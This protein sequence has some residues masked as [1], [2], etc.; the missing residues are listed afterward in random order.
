[1]NPVRKMRQQAAVAFLLC[2]LGVSAAAPSAASQN[3]A[4][5]SA[6]S[7]STASSAVSSAT[8]VPPQIAALIAQIDAL[9][10]DAASADADYVQKLMDAYDALS[11][12]ERL[13]V[14]NSDRLSEIYDQLAQSGAVSR[15]AS[16]TPTPDTGAADG[17]KVIQTT[18]YRFSVGEK[19]SLSI[20]VRFVTDLDGDGKGDIPDR[21]V[22]T[23]PY[24]NTTPITRT[25]SSLHD[26]TMDI[27]LIWEANF[28]QRDIRSAETGTWSL[29]TSA[30][31]TVSRMA[32]A[33]ARKKIIP[34]S[35]SIKP[36]A[37]GTVSSLTPVPEESE[38][39][40][41][42]T[43]ETGSSANGGLVR[44]AAIAVIGIALMVFLFRFS[45]KSGKKTETKTDGYTAE[46]PDD[47]KKFA[48]AE[49][50]V[51]SMKAAMEQSELAE[52]EESGKVG[53]DPDQAD[54]GQEAADDGNLSE[55]QEADDGLTSYTE[56]DT[57][58][59]T[60]EDRPGQEPPQQPEGP[61]E[62]TADDAEADSDDA[63][64]GDLS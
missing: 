53:A 56:G 35:T 4:S 64:F 42:G 61:L 33:G 24:G 30:A 62:E 52:I 17:D 51:E 11:L 2:A 22:L 10:D 46:E 50:D 1:M 47:L 16:G 39:P 7:G 20:V 29:E 60:K 6:L 27:D 18:R 8:S 3:T 55:E 43:E 21:M 15:A 48:D 41:V 45:K 26:N 25:A 9:P 34:E 31:V 38:A 40:A 54:T 12:S 59:L 32:Y 44:T 36:A 63:D 5:S 13:Q 14:T 49:D 57:S 37:S 28:L 58:L 19:D 23:D